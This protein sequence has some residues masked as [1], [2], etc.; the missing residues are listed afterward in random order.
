MDQDVLDY[1]VNLKTQSESYRDKAA[2]L[3]DSFT[4]TASGTVGYMVRLLVNNAGK[5]KLV[6]RAGD[7]TKQLKEPKEIDKIFSGTKLSSDISLM[8]LAYNAMYPNSSDFGI[9]GPNKEMI[10][11]ISQNNFQ[12]AKLRNIN[13]TGGKHAADMMKSPYARHSIILDTAKEFE[14]NVSD[15]DQFQLNLEVGLK[16][17][18]S[19]EGADFFG[20]TTLE[21]YIQMMLTLD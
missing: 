14:D 17:G 11:P 7:A 3:K 21:D 13:L 20:T 10:Y 2:V 16:D 8:A 19:Q 9:F 12:S 18:T 15:D 5:D 1:F 6:N 4:K